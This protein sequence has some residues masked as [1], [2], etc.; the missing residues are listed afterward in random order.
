MGITRA[1]DAVVLVWFD[2]ICYPNINL[3]IGA[4]TGIANEVEPRNVDL[5]PNRGMRGRWS[6]VCGSHQGN[7][8]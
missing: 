8:I 7:R 3:N 6:G 1:T 4:N 2:T 5:N